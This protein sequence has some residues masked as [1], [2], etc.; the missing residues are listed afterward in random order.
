M[1]SLCDF[2][3]ERPGPSL[4]LLALYPSFQAI[5]LEA[6][7]AS[8]VFRFSPLSGRLVYLVGRA[9]PMFSCFLCRLLVVSRPPA[10]P[11][12]TCRIFA[13]LWPPRPLVVPAFACRPSLACRPL[14]RFSCPRLFVVLLP[15]TSSHY[16]QCLQFSNIA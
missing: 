4:G 9:R 13:R 5:S 8:F 7:T 16:F 3:Y 1:S 6:R 10:V 11:W 12:P 2:S 14:I 15:Q